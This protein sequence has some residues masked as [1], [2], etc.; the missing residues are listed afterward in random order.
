MFHSRNICHICEKQFE[1]KSKLTKH[2]NRVHRI[3]SHQCEQCG[4]TTQF[5]ASL[6]NHSRKHTK[7]RPFLCNHP[8]CDSRFKDISHLNEHT[9]IHNKGNFECFFC[10]K[11]CHSRT[12]IRVHLI[13]QHSSLAVKG[14]KCDICG[15]FY[16]SKYVMQEH[17]RIHS[18]Q[19]NFV[20]KWCPDKKYLTSGSLRIHNRRTHAVLYRCP[21]CRK[22]Y[23]KKDS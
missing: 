8:G 21:V 16:K 9:K 4:Y 2:K 14:Y 11:L 13:N 17:T 12:R 20:C 6:I 15:K 7:E 10:G 3:K 22:G 23:L 18:G 5:R 1:D 19:R